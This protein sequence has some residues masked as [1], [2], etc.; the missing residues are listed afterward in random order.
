MTIRN[1]LTLQFTTLVGIILLAVLLSIYL[2]TEVI[3]RKGFYERLKERADI[4]AQNFLEQDELPTSSYSLVHQKF[5]KGL[6]G[7]IILLFDSTNHRQFV[8]STDHRQFVAGNL[9][10]S[11]SKELLDRV[12]NER[13][14]YGAQ[15]PNQFVGIYY[16]DNQGNF[17]IFA[18][19]PDDIGNGRLQDLIRLMIISYIIALVIIYFSGRFFSRKALESIPKVVQQ[20]NKITASNL[21]LRLDEGKNKDEI[22]ELACTF[23]NML[24]RLESSFEMQKTFVSNASHELRT[25]LTSIIGELEVFLSKERTPE[26]YREA[27]QSVLNDAHQMNELTSGLLDIAQID[28]NRSEIK[29]EDIRLDELLVE[30]EKE[31]SA[32]HPQSKILLNYADLPEDASKLIVK[33][34]KQLLSIAL[35]NL[36]HNGIKFSNN[37]PV[38]CN[39]RYINDHI[40]VRIIDKGIGIP[41]EEIN[42]VFQPF[43]RS[44]GA[45]N[46]SGHGVGLSLVE[47]ILQLHQIKITIQSAIGKGTEVLLVFNPD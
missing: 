20:V 41:E 8:D 5:L 25:P 43:Y 1:R 12:R 46:F 45:R 10:I 35:S 14:V 3:T 33:G 11:F 4:T 16:E 18:A 9:G 15:K 24:T 6:A 2:V 39:L 29:L 32:Q 37:N 22:R 44:Q 23:N 38:N 17:V 21:H 36:F 47:K 40:E 26:Q 7:E 28:F 34:N 27:M 31:V 42:K 30:I 19:A 13:V